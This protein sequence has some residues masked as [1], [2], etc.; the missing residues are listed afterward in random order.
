MIEMTNEEYHANLTHLSSSALKLLHKDKSPDK[1]A[2]DIEKFYQQYILGNWENKKSGPLEIGTAVHTAILEPHLFESSIAVF[3]GNRRSGKAWEEFLMQNP[4]KTLLR[5]DDKVLVDALLATYNNNNAAKE[6]LANCK[7][8]YTIMTNLY[9]LPVKCRCDAINVDKRYIVDIKTTSFDSSTD[10]FKDTVNDMSYDLSAELYRRI[11]QN[12]FGVDFDFYFVVL[13]KNDF[14]CKIYKT[15][16]N[17]F[18]IGNDR[19]LSAIDTYKHFKLTGEF[20]KDILVVDEEV[21]EI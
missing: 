11:A 8:E 5:T 14:K 21:T 17:T 4:K 6:L 2:R 15:S 13:S 1:I 20:K 12:H 3:N 19:L 7:F 9:D 16:K 10:S 18:Q